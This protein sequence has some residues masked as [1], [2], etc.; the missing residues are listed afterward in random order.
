MEIYERIRELRKDHLNMSQAVFGKKLGV[1]RDVIN[2]IENNRLSRPEQ[3]EPLYKLICKEF[4]V[5]YDWLVHGVGEP[6]REDLDEDEYTRA[7]A[8]IGCNDPRAQQALIKYW[9]LTDEDKKLF[10]EFM[11]KFVLKKQRDD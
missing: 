7:S 3:K 4:H 9:K 5:S 8:E 10:W 11:D 1:N 6:F 2:N